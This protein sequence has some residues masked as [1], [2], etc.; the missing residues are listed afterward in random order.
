MTTLA[1]KTAAY[2]KEF[3]KRMKIIEVQY[4]T[5]HVLNIVQN[6]S[7]GITCCIQ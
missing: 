5:R 4:G 1:H 2:E 7:S 3:E 6:V